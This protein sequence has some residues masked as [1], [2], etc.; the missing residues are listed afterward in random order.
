MK[1]IGLDVGTKRIGVAK[2]DSNVKIAVPHTTLEVNG[3]EFE[4]IAHIAKI[5]S[6]GHIVIGLPR[7]SKGEETAQSTY[8]REF[9]IKLKTLLTDTKI[10]LQDK[11]LTSVETE[12][13]Y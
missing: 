10:Y 8:S 6:A 4:Q 7:N 1:V 12:N 5:Y 11:S 13:L 2:A 3:T 9:A